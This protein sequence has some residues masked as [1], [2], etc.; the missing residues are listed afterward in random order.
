VFVC[1]FACSK[2]FKISPDGCCLLCMGLFEW[3]ET[4]GEAAVK[5]VSEGRK[6]EHFHTKIDLGASH[7]LRETLFKHA[8]AVADIVTVNVVCVPI[9]EKVVAKALPSFRLSKE[10]EGMCFSL[11]QS[12]GPL[13]DVFL[14]E[15]PKQ[16]GRKRR[17][18]AESKLNKTTLAKYLDKRSVQSIV[19]KFSSLNQPVRFSKAVI[20]GEL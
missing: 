9:L 4:E 1:Y 18:L 3:L 15:P 8:Y 14:P 7:V 10:T 6:F 5:A 19:D 20:E 11:T 13:D 12:C 17:T 2:P 16:K